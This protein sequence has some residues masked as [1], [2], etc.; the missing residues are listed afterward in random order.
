MN[1]VADAAG[2]SQAAVSLVLN[3]GGR[4]R[5]SQATAQRVRQAATDL[6]YTTNAHAKMLREGRSRLIGFISDEVAT[7]PFAG[8]L[9]KGAQAQAWSRDHLLQVV[10]TGGDPDVEAAALKMLLSHRVVGVVYSAMYHRVVTVPDVLASVPVVCLNAQDAVGRVMSIFPDEELGG[11]Q[12][13][14]LVVA[15]GHRDVAVINI[16]PEGANVPAAAGRL[17]GF[18]D[19][20]NARGV[21]LPP[22]RIK[23]GDGNHASGLEL[24]RE[25]L[26][27]PTRPTA[28]F[29]LNDRTALGCYHAL[30]EAG[31]RVPDD[32]SVIGFDDQDVLRDC[33]VPR[34]TTFQL[35]FEEMGRLAVAALLDGEQSS[36]RRVPVPCPV[37]ERAS[38]AVRSET[39]TVG[40]VEAAH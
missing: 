9:I 20:L 24:T 1:D 13:A 11:R 33:F 29:C 32:V 10:D 37:I 22:E 31:L 19:V 26:N 16:A 40:A 25:L 30:A 35:P 39:A 21:A 18:S 3:G 17:R 12:A 36:G 15:A 34:L 27:S 2:V 23:V 38:V 28:I 14:E 4:G 7:A 6:G 8:S 5:V